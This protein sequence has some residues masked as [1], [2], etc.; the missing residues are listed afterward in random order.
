MILSADNGK[1][2]NLH[3][4][5]GDGKTAIGIS[6]LISQLSNLEIRFRGNQNY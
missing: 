6:N 1:K 4:I 5:S 2:E 3:R